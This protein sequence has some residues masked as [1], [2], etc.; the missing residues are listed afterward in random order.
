MT[1][2]TS[3]FWTT[4]GTALQFF[5]NRPHTETGLQILQRDYNR[6]MFENRHWL[7]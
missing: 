1:R 7:L 5:S 3:P 6:I 2:H 4:L